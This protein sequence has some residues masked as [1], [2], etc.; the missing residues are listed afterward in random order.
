MRNASL[1]PLKSPAAYLKDALKKGYTGVKGSKTDEPPTPSAAVLPSLAITDAERLRRLRE[2]WENDRMKQAR[3][4]F[5]EMAQD[6]QD[7]WRSRFEAVQ[8]EL[9]ALPIVKAWRRD[10]PAS[11][12]AG[13][14][15]FRWLAIETWP[16]TPTDKV[17][18]EFALHRGVSGI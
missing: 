11:R 5:L 13:T 15:F 18:L 7:H 6:Q 8:L 12:I 16:E 14:S 9:L 10:G 2:L 1:D 3:E 17:L 4:M